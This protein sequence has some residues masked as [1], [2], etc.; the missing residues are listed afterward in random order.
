MSWK[1]W[2]CGTTLLLAALPALAQRQH[3]D[4][5]DYP[6]SEANWD[7]FHALEGAL[8]GEFDRL[9]ADTFCE[10]GYSNYR[11]MQFRCAVAEVAGT[12]QQCAWVV[13]A[14]ELQVE[15]GLGE[16]QVDNGRWIC[17]VVL[18][19]IPVEAFHAAL[20]RPG[21]LTEPFPGSGG[22]LFDVLPDCLQGPGNTGR[23]A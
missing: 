6:S 3:V 4:L 19:G 13:A 2:C 8:M 16:V 18:P 23:G 22:G 11:V 7:R 5:V 15:P 10:G 20:E 14:S 12:V 9:C 17:R 1:A 21:G